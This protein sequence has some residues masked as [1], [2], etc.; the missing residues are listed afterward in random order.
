MHVI[1]LN[2][3]F[4]SARSLA[5]STSLK[6]LIISF[7]INDSSYRQVVCH[8]SLSSLP[9]PF[10]KRKIS[11]WHGGEHRTLCIVCSTCLAKKARA[12]T[13]LNIPSWDPLYCQFIS[14]ASITSPMWRSERQIHPWCNTTAL[15]G[16]VAELN[17][18]QTLCFDWLYLPISD[19]LSVAAISSYHKHRSYR[20]AYVKQINRFSPSPA[21]IRH[22][23]ATSLLDVFV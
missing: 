1:W 22:L 9:L 13:T 11:L 12:F 18:H 4:C 16:V 19:H 6:G 14:P 7:H 5:V 2:I 15:S 23:S 21:S 10:T 17:L 20:H 3:F 8:L